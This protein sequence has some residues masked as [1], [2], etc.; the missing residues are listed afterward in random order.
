MPA[1]EKSVS[2]GVGFRTKY[3]EVASGVFAPVVVVMSPLDAGAGAGATA[4]TVADGADVTFGAKADAAAAADGSTASFMSLFRRLLGKFP[5]SIGPK[6]AAGALAVTIA[7]DDAALGT[8]IDAAPALGAGGVGVNGWLSTL[9]LRLPA[10]LGL[11]ASA[12]SLPVVLASDDAQIGTKPTASTA[13]GAGATGLIGWLATVRDVL[14]TSLPATLGLKAS[15]ASLPVVLAS[16]DAQIGT[17]VT[18]IPALASG[19]TGLIGWLSAQWQALI[20]LGLQLPATLGIKASTASLSITAASDANLAR[21]TYSSVVAMSTPTLAAGATFNP[22]TGQA[23]SQ[24][25]LIAP[26]TVDIEYRR[27]GAGVA[28]PIAAGTSRLI[29]GLANA[30]QIAVRRL[31]QSATPVNTFAEAYTV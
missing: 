8:K 18:V 7:S 24:L 20:N 23:C 15:A 3:V 9:A 29:Q 1:E 14:I 12:A 13:L 21:E 16:D 22:F 5:I 31:D 2:T 10:S 30:N 27:G 6:T 17:K 19:G 25:D 11:K 26:P 4:V 28:I